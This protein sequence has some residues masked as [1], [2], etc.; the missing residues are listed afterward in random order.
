[1][2]YPE[3]LPDTEVFVFSSTPLNV[4]FFV[5]LALPAA[6][7]VFSALG[8]VTYS[9]PMLSSHELFFI[10]IIQPITVEELILDFDFLTGLH[11]FLHVWTVASKTRKLDSGILNALKL[12]LSPSP[13]RESPSA[14]NT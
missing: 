1:M 13:A 3:H 8:A 6:K 5:G 9:L 10:D 14:G 12:V 2:I 11:P 4:I 7:A